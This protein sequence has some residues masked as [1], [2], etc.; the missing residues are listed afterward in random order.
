M[1]RSH[2]LRRELTGVASEFLFEVYGYNFRNTDL[3]ATLGL[4]Q[5]KR[6]DDMIDARSDNFYEYMKVMDRHRVLFFTKPSDDQI[7]YNSSFCFPF[8][9]RTE[10]QL[11]H[12]KRL[13]KFE[14]IETRPIIA[15]NLLRHPAYSKFDYPGF[16]YM[17]ADVAHYQGIYIGNNHFLKPKHFKTLDKILGRIQE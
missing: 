9:F 6:L 12:A 8:V 10:E 16:T 15:G 17:N 11:Q 5:L 4:S 2:G 7:Y 13:F 1:M 14:G 3:G